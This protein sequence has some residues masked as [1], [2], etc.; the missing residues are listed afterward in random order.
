VTLSLTKAHLI[1]DYP[2]VEI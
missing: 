2:I 1:A